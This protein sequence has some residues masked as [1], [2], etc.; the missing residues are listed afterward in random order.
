M[1]PP[2]ASKGSTPPHRA[3]FYKGDSTTSTGRTP[4]VWLLPDSNRLTIRVTTES[5]ADLAV[6]S[7]IHIPTFEWT[8]LTFVF[9]NTTK[10]GVA[11][12][13]QCTTAGNTKTIIEDAA[14]K[15]VLVSTEIDH[16]FLSVEG[17]TQCYDDEGPMDGSTW[18]N[19][20]AY[21]NKQ[22]DVRY[23]SCALLAQISSKEIVFFSASF[24]SKV[25]GNS[26]EL[27]LFNDPSHQ[28]IYLQ[29]TY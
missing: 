25:L 24:R 4:S 22:L 26:E 10:S 2:V 14:A 28:G 3:L 8:L 1:D 23:F 13:E 20:K 9:S 18:F 19:I 12:N 27:R 11:L 29:C 17:D 21:V 16:F 7:F 15:G 5:E 6:E